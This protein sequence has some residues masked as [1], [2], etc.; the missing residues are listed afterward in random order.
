MTNIETRR[1]K[2]DGINT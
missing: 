2:V 1:M